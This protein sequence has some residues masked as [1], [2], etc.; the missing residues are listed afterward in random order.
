MALGS[1]GGERGESCS[2]LDVDVISVDG[3]DSEVKASGLCELS[4]SSVSRETAEV[5]ALASVLVGGACSKDVTCSGDGSPWLSPTLLADAVAAL[6]LAGRDEQEVSQ[7]NGL[8]SSSLGSLPVC[9]FEGMDGT[10][11]PTDDGKAGEEKI[12]KKVMVDLAKQAI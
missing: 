9:T 1:D 6:E 10:I 4:I 7:D 11:S 12:D 2:W 3:S 5:L 8:G